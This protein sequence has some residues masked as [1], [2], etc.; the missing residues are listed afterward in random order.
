MFK[1]VFLFYNGFTGGDRPGRPGGRIASYPVA[2]ERLQAIIACGAGIPVRPALAPDELAG[3]R[4]LDSPRLRGVPGVKGYAAGSRRLY[5]RGVKRWLAGRNRI[6]EALRKTAGSRRAIARRPYALAGR[7]SRRSPGQRP[8]RSIIPLSDPDAGSLLL[9][10]PDTTGHVR[11]SSGK[12]SCRAL[13]R[14]SGLH[15]L[16]GLPLCGKTCICRHV[17]ALAHLSARSDGKRG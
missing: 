13:A 10:G 9:C 3:A 6:R 4:G 2:P 8:G 15:H 11:R 14:G 1:S 17:S 7:S 12:A 5:W 16:R